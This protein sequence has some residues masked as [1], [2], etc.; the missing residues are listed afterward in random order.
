MMLS[1]TC[2]RVEGGGGTVAASSS[3]GGGGI[4]SMEAVC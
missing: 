4:I 3:G 1:R 2:D